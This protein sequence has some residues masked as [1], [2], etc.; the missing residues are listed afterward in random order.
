MQKY[1]ITVEEGKMSEVNSSLISIGF[2]VDQL[3]EEVNCITG[4][5][6]SNAGEKI[7]HISGVIDVTLDEEVKL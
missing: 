1:I 5:C 2:I 3:L 4:T 7:S 6:D